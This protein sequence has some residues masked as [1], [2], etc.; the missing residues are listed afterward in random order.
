M[1]PSVQIPK[2]VSGQPSPELG[3]GRSDS[4]IYFYKLIYSL[5]LF[6]SRTLLYC[7]V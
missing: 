3:D 5:A 6:Q 1:N 4:F 7:K 2:L